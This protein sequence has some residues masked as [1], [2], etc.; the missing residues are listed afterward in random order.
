MEGSPLSEGLIGPRSAAKTATPTVTGN[1]AA[2]SL[3]AP[4]PPD[5]TQTFS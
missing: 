5:K 2:T 4:R 3:E 1:L